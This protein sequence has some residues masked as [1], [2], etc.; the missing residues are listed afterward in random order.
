MQYRYIVVAQFVFGGFGRLPAGCFDTS[1]ATPVVHDRYGTVYRMEGP[2]RP[3]ACF[4]VTN[5]DGGASKPA[6]ATR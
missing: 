5:A 4:H 2:L 3:A 1:V 6:I